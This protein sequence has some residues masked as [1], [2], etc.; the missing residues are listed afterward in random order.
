VNLAGH[1]RMGMI[2]DL[3]HCWIVGLWAVFMVYWAIAAMF[4]KRGDR[5]GWRSGLTIRLALFAII[6]VAVSLA[7]RSPELRALQ[8]AEL[9][10]LPMAV[11][12][13]VIATLGA[14]LAFTARAVIGRNWGSP[15]TRKTDT[16]L[17]TGGPYSLIR[18]PIY[19]GVLLMMIGTAI[20]LTPVWWLVA[21]AAGTYFIS[22]ARA[23]E[24]FMT[25]RFPDLY[26]AY[27]ARTKMLVPFI[28]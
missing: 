21:A 8:W 5:G 28:F 23:E 2:L 1:D 6:F 9:R 3:C 24:R 20:G 16:Q 18:H 10:S 13:A 4:V 19:S 26:P 7:S 27:R 11:S 25:E 14:I 17:V 12:G 15:A 22:S